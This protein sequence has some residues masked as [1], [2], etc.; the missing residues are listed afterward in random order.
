M[1]SYKIKP[2][3]IKVTEFRYADKITFL[4][5]AERVD[6]N[7]ASEAKNYT[8]CDDLCIGTRKNRRHFRA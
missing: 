5:S 2:I 7:N 3:V 8:I 4:V 6:P 1:Y